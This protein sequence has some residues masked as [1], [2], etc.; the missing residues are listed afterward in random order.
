MSWNR[1]R[2]PVTI[3]VGRPLAAAAPIA[4]GEQPVDPVGAAVGEEAHVRRGPSAGTPPGLGSACSTRCRR[5]RRRRRAPRA[6][7][8]ARARTARRA[9]PAPPRSPPRRAAPASSQARSHEP[10]AGSARARAATPCR[11]RGRVGAD[12]RRR[13]PGR[14]VP[15][16][17]GVDDDLRGAARARRATRAAACR[18]AARRNAGR[19]P[20]PAPPAA[21]A[22]SARSCGRRPGP[23]VGAEAQ[24]RGRLGEDRVPGGAREGG[25]RLR[26]ARDRRMRPAMISPRSAPATRSAIASDRGS[27]AGAGAPWIGGQWPSRV[28]AFERQRR[29]RDHLARPRL[30][31][32]RIAPGDVQVYGAG[33]GIAGG[34]R[35]RRGRRRSGSAAS[36][37]SSAS[38]VPTSQNHRTAAP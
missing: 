3:Q 2:S 35:D 4:R 29:A 25:D 9:A 10:L 26:R 20:G 24:L 36:P 28:A 13:D 11:H 32:E 16:A 5:G 33:A 19:G 37:T 6:P 15:A 1:P 17:A 21:R 12:D 34:D 23:V 30:R 14:L 38:W 22:R 8:A 18:S 27:A 7:P 31:A